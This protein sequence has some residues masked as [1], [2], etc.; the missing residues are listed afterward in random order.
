M[1]TNIRSLMPDV[2][3]IIIGLS[4]MLIGG[5]IATIYVGIANM[6][7]SSFVNISKTTV[8]NYV[9]SVATYVPMI[10]QM[11]GLSILIVAVVHIIMLLL[12]VARK[13]GEVAGV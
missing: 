5:L 12:Q 9:T 1:S 8:T 6:V 7:V 11:L 4:L 13:P 10:L 3:G 2:L